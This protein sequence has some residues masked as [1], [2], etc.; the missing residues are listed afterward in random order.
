MTPAAQPNNKTNFIKPAMFFVSL[1]LYVI[2]THTKR[3]K[4]GMYVTVV[5]LLIFR[6]F[7]PNAVKIKTYIWVNA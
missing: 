2:L 7:V 3:K 1:C 5:Y 6:I 4:L